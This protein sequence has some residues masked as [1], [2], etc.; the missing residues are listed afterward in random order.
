MEISEM[1]SALER[2]EN[3]LF[4]CRHALGILSVDGVTAAPK[5]SSR[6]RERTVGVLSE[7]EYRLRCGEDT[8]RLL[9]KMEEKAP[10]LPARARREVHELL[11]EFRRTACIPM[12]EYAEYARTVSR[13]SDVW[14]ESKDRSD[15]ASFLPWLERI[16]GMNRRFA[17]YRDSG[18]DPYDT[19]LD[20]YEKGASRAS[21]DA[22][23]ALLRERLVPLI[24]AVGEKPLP[25]EMKGR[26]PVEKQ[27]ILTDRL[28]EIMGLDRQYCAVAE[29][30]HPF[31]DAFSRWDVRI[32]THY[33]ESDPLSSLYSVVHEGGHALY[34][35]GTGEDIQFTCLGTGSSMGIHESQSRF[36]EN[37][38][39]RSEGFIRL[40]HPIMCSLF[41]EEMRAYSP[42]DMY[43]AANRAM[44]S[45]IR[46]EADELTYPL[47]IMVR[48]E[49]E[50][51]LFDGDL[52]C[53][54]L[55]GAWAEMYRKYLGIAPSDDREGVLQDSHWA[56]GAF[57]YFPSYALGSAYGAQMLDV[58]K[59]TVDVDGAVRAGDLSPITLWLRE[60][61]HRHGCMM[62]PPELL[63]NAF[64]GAPFD[65]EY[66]I[67]YL[68]D[69]FSALYGL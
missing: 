17:L 50:K 48:Y 18:K 69:K 38:I 1:L 58:M 68:T 60:R 10:L 45:L 44:P 7:T 34:E 59:K 67:R 37:I 51:A 9:E 5:G 53:G 41:P 19:L 16:V 29:T 20:D 55:P 47:H 33:Y 63:S 3:E 35:A 49:L 28:M 46:T 30:E 40:V 21:L 52:S 12:E 65:P 2:L 32:T 39:G 26:F 57:G 43:R 62:D 4:A 15:F 64:D 23:F 6:P 31:T 14:H 27:R 54:D 36:Y 25:R 24:R 66:Y 42:E 61:I 56:G 22:F 11:K 13:A 8:R